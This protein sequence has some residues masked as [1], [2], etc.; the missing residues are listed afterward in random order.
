MRTPES[1]A[2]TKRYVEAM[3]EVIRRNQ[4]NGGDITS[5][6]AFA[7][8]LGHSVQN[9]NK[10]TNG[11]QDVTLDLLIQSA[12]TYG[13]NP[14]FVLLDLGE[15][16]LSEVKVNHQNN[17]RILKDKFLADSPFAKPKKKK[18]KVRR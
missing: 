5:E 4:D 15:K 11:I 8:S 1:K 18:L 12:K 16:F 9:I 14:I 7:E 13:I 2:A 6:T 10:L 3:R 17:G